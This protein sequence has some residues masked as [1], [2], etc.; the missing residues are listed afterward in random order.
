MEMF[1]DSA[2][3]DE[4]KRAVEMWDIDGVSLVPTMRKPFDLL[5]EGLISKDSR[6]DWIRTSDLLTPSQ[7]RYP[8]CATPRN[9]LDR[10]RAVRSGRRAAA[11]PIVRRPRRWDASTNRASVS[12]AHR[13]RPCNAARAAASPRI[14]AARR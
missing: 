11:S 7:T 14:M 9:L 1:L 3:T 8:G 4:I 12:M 2:K 5:A 13:R 6:G 10:G